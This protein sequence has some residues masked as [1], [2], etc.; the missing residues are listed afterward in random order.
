MASS[1]TLDLPRWRV[2][3]PE[4]TATTDDAVVAAYGWAL[5][6]N[7]LSDDA[8]QALTA[9]IL[10]LAEQRTAAADGGSGIVTA[11]ALGPQRREYMA[12]SMDARQVWL[13]QSVYGRMVVMLEQRAPA[14]VMSSSWS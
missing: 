9:H 3:Y 6:I 13:T 11:E 4:F 2:T 12:Q 1:A 10:T 5:Q 7:A 8:T 14:V